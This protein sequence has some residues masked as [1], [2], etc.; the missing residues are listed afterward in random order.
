MAP[1]VQPR[2]PNVKV[3]IEDVITKDGKF[4]SSKFWK[5]SDAQIADLIGDAVYDVRTY[6]VQP[7]T[8][9]KAASSV[10]LLEALDKEDPGLGLG[11]YVTL[12]KSMKSGNGSAL[13]KNYFDSLKQYDPDTFNLYLKHPGWE[14]YDGPDFDF[15]TYKAENMPKDIEPTTGA[16]SSNPI[17]NAPPVEASP[18]ALTNPD[19]FEVG[20]KRLSYQSFDDA[21][22]NAILAKGSKEAEANAYTGEEPPIADYGTPITSPGVHVTFINAEG[23]PVDLTSE[24][25][26]RFKP[27]SVSASS[28]PSPK[29]IGEAMRDAVKEDTSKDA[30]VT[31]SP[32]AA[33]KT[34]AEA[35]AKETETKTGTGTEAKAEAVTE[36]KITP[37]TAE[38]EG[39]LTGNR[40]K[41]AFI[42]TKDFIKEHP[43]W[44]I[45]GLLT[46]AAAGY[47]IS[48]LPKLIKLPETK[49]NVYRN[50]NE[51]TA[52]PEVLD[53]VNYRVWENY[54]PDYLNEEYVPGKIPSYISQDNLSPIKESTTSKKVKSQSQVVDTPAPVNNATA[55][56]VR[57]AYNSYIPSD[58]GRAY[59][60]AIYGDPLELDRMRLQQQQ[61]KWRDFVMR[62]GQS[63]AELVQRGLMPYDALQYV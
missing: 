30:T 38:T 18:G 31:I 41:N 17:N 35:V 53:N 45:G 10:R 22:L 52:T 63:P 20:P 61:Q 47:G 26:A 16:L 8:S 34:E 3:R 25:I 15:T 42:K 46:L 51:K 39:V 11:H 44:S 58:A 12:F 59:Q 48:Q 7:S 55:D 1:K 37:E 23:K 32:E 57:A 21:E 6:I 4:D 14:A 50:R 9:K 24:E 2:V 49:V 36:P 62:S 43:K 40:F 54:N 27:N 13:T 60:K 5:L 56:Y 28:A 29:A 19:A 33:A